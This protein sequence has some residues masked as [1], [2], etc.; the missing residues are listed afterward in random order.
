MQDTTLSIPITSCWSVSVINCQAWASTYKTRSAQRVECVTSNSALAVATLRS[1]ICRSQSKIDNCFQGKT[2]TST[3]GSSDLVILVGSTVL[4]RGLSVG[5]MR[6]ALELKNVRALDNF[7][8]FLGG[9]VTDTTSASKSFDLSSRRLGVF[10]SLVTPIHHLRHSTVSVSESGRKRS[11]FKTSTNEMLLIIPR[12]R[13]AAIVVFAP[14]T[15]SSEITGKRLRKPEN[16]GSGMWTWPTFRTPSEMME[17][18]WVVTQA[19]K[20][21]S[22]R[23]DTTGDGMEGWNVKNLSTCRA[24]LR[25]FV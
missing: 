1:I 5:M 7:M 24:C 9:P 15:I 6:S 22:I 10:P 3:S 17:K 13:R 8:V 2:D 21:F 18:G 4:G 19:K 12:E 14:L 25:S 20:A 16:S 11:S 23:L